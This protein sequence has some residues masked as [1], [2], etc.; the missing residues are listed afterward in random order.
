MHVRAF[1]FACRQPQFQDGMKPQ[2]ALCWP[3]GT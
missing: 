3:S 2:S 1:F